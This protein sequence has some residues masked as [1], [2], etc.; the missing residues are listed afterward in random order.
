MKYKNQAFEVESDYLV[1]RETWRKLKCL[2]TGLEFTNAEF[3]AYCK[4][5]GIQRQLTSPRTPEQNGVA[6]SDSS[7]EVP[8]IE[9]AGSAEAMQFAC[10]V[11]NRSPNRRL[12]GDIPEE[13]WTKTKIRY[14]TLRIFGFIHAARRPTQS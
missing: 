6:E 1:E 3:M 7:R 14:E 8:S 13:L 4:R 12:N 11:I 2:R 5:K 9:I 10:Y